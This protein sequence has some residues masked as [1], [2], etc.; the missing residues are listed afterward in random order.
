[1]PEDFESLFPDV[2]IVKGD[3]D[4]TD[5]ISSTAEQANIVIHNGDSDH[6]PSLNAIM[7]GLLRRAT[8]G[9]LLHL[10]GTGIVSDWSSLQYL[11][12]LNP[13]VWSDDD[14][15]ALKKIKALPNDALHRN[16]EKILHKT[17][18]EKPDRI[19]IAIMCPP[20]IF[21][22]GKGPGKTDTVFFSLFW[23]VVK[24]LDGRTFYHKEGTNT[25]SWVHIDDLMRLYVRVVEA[26]ASGFGQEIEQYFGPN[27]YHFAATQEYSQME[28][29]VESG[30]ICKRHGLIQD[31]Q[32]VQTSLEEMDGMQLHPAY[33]QVARYLFA[34]NSRTRADRAK[35][36]WQYE[37]KSNGLMD[38]L[39]DE[40]LRAVGITEETMM[41]KS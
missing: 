18:K 7:E 2:T 12:R 27:G 5:I 24:N 38:C 32:P 35:R 39:E 6:E 34:S 21:G 28:V 11:G 36:L 30:R 40:L 8:P 31:E 33:P 19:K 14:E 9:Y 1:V 29:A 17:I 10:S 15:E 16:T 20:D 41:M 3:Y 4:S 23:D 13:E 26:A 25:R 37:G 22:K